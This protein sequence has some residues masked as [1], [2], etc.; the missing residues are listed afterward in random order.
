[1][2]IAF[3]PAIR[4]NYEKLR[5]WPRK[6]LQNLREMGRLVLDARVEVDPTRGEPRSTS[7]V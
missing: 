2:S 4:G 5:N 6:G 1:M 7:S 3:G